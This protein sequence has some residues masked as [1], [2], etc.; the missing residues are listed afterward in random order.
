MIKFLSLLFLSLL[1]S[2]SSACSCPGPPDLNATLYEKDSIVLRGRILDE[3]KLTTTD[4]FGNYDRFFAFKVKK[5]HKAPCY[6]QVGDV[7]LVSTGGNDGLCGVELL[8]P[9]TPYTFSGS[10][11]NSN[12]EEP[13]MVQVRVG[14]CDYLVEG[15]NPPKADKRVLGAY[16]KA[17]PHPTTCP[18]T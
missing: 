9:G 12:P 17:N 16:K 14:S 4:E 7:I 18:A 1:P 11:D 10:S 2:L 3:I 6:I 15:N 13:T 8:P 5:V